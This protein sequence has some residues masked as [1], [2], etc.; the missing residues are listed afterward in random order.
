MV[1]PIRLQRRPY[2]K[3]YLKVPEQHKF[4]SMISFQGKNFGRW[5]DTEEFGRGDYSE[6]RLLD[7][8]NI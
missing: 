6:N 1:Y 7:I 3:K 4:D 5:V 2:N 8:F